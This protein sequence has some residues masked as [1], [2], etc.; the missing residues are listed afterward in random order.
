LRWH[1]TKLKLDRVHARVANLRCDAIHKATTRLAKT[2]GQVIIEDLPV[3]QLVRGIRSHRKS[4][5]DAAAGRLRRQ[6]A[7]K[8]AWYGS[9]LWIA[10]RF[11]PSSKT[12]SSCGQVNA[13]LTMADRAWTCRRAMQS[14]TGTKMPGLTWHACRPVGP[15]R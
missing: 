15:R 12:C 14:M 11:Y 9:E 7:Y 2:H 6:L 5:L 8:A 13:T 4:W 3:R 10:D 1:K